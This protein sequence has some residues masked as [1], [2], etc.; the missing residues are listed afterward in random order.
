MQNFSKFS[1][2]PQIFSNCCNTFSKNFI[3]FQYDFKFSLKLS[4][5]ETKTSVSTIE[6]YR[7]QY[8]PKYMKDE[9]KIYNKIDIKI[10]KQFTISTI[11]KCPHFI[12]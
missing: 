8:F 6:F 3:K 2:Y 1:R 11:Y 9:V 7:I 12:Y 4:T 10:I 5:T